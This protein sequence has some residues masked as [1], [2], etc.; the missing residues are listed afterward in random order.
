MFIHQYVIYTHPPDLIRRVPEV[1]PGYPDR[2]LPVDDKAA[3]I[4]KE[5]PLTKLYNERPMWLA[6]AHRGL[7]AVVAA[8]Y[9]WQPDL[10]EEEILSRLLALNQTRSHTQS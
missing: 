10:S 2:I 6:N 8:A 7:D 5:R 4:L 9:G 1:I 3:A